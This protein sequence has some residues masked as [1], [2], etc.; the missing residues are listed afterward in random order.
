VVRARDGSLETELINIDIVFKAL[1]I[2]NLGRKWRMRKKGPD[3][4]F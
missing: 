3:A 1:G 4:E 2:N